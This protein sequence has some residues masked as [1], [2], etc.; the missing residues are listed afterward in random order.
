MVR[1]EFGL[2]HCYEIALD[3]VEQ[4]KSRNSLGTN[5]KLVRRDI[6]DENVK[7]V[8]GVF[9]FLIMD[10]LGHDKYKF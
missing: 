10:F 2:I 8:C 5:S 4:L 6:I 3:V 1:K 9:G 7:D